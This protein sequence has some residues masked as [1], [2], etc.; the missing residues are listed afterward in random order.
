MSLVS[1]VSSILSFQ[2]FNSFS[3]IHISSLSE[4]DQIKTRVELQSD[5]DTTISNEIMS[6]ADYMCL[7]NKI[8][9]SGKYNFE[10]C[11]VSLNHR[12]KIDCF[13]FM[14]LDYSDNLLCEFIEFGFSD[15]LFWQTSIQKF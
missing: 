12:L 5:K 6:N 4:T 9:I 7:H 3:E 2:K 8:L 15:T 10:S 14:L 11:R 13:R 1:N